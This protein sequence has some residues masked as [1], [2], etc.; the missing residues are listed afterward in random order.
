MLIYAI[1]QIAKEYPPRHLACSN[2]SLS[3]QY[4]INELNS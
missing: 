2:R 1:Q 3:M 4:A